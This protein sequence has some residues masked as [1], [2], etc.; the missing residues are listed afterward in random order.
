[1]YFKKMSADRCKQ[2]KMET[3][4]PKKELVETSLKNHL[5]THYSVFYK[6]LTYGEKYRNNRIHMQP[7]TWMCNEFWKHVPD[8]NQCNEQV[9]RWISIASTSLPYIY[10]YWHAKY[11]VHNQIQIPF[12]LIYTHD[13]ILIQ[14]C[15]TDWVQ[16]KGHVSTLLAMTTLLE[17]KISQVKHLC[18]IN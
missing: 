1:M 18:G 14:I 4:F 17:S 13:T 12:A 7:G 3:N 6:F 10:V 2:Y 16:G 11:I 8:G 5:K 15:T 9:P